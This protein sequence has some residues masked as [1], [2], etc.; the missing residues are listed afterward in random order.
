MESLESV[1]EDLANG[2]AMA[3]FLAAGFGT[4]A[5]GFVIYLNE[6]GHFVPPVL[7]APAGGV[8]GRTTLA[9]ASWLI[10][11]AV[12]HVGMRNR[13]FTSRAVPILSLLLTVAGIVMML[14][15]VWEF[16]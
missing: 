13:Q 11:W 4:F 12:L 1:R 9:V 2:A 16:F 5:M 3:A 14:P 10:I 8:S 6:A 15:P 7:Y